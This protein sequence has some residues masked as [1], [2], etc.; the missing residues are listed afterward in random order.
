MRAD[1]AG[2]SFRISKTRAGWSWAAFDA[3]GHPI[4]S[5]AAPNR[6]VAA[7]CVIRVIARSEAP[8][9]APVGQRL[10]G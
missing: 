1:A 5:G 2:C 9:A 6:A 8:D 3:A 4:E 7:A 10:A